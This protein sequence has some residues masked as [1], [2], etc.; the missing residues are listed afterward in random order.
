[1]LILGRIFCGKPASTFPENALV[2]KELGSSFMQPDGIALA[3]VSKPD[4]VLRDHRG[5]LI[6]ALHMRL[7]QDVLKY[8]NQDVG[9]RGVESFTLKQAIDRHAVCAPG[10]WEPVSRQGF[11]GVENTR[12][13]SNQADG[14]SCSQA[15][16]YCLV[17]TELQSVANWRHHARSAI[18]TVM[19]MVERTTIRTISNDP[20]PP[21]GDTPNILSMKA[22]TVLRPH[23]V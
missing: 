14:M 10:R 16:T 21:S 18:M 4:D 17:A 1:M 7:A 2:A 20:L 11:I 3:G 8:R 6:G 9:G 15:P 13:R 5:D 23:S 19:A 12:Q 22:M